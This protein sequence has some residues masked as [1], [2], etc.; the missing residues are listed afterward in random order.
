MKKVGDI[1]AAYL[2]RFQDNE[3]T[4][5]WFGVV[6]SWQDVVGPSLA[7]HTKVA[8]LDGDTLVI[9]AQHP[10]SAQLVMMKQTAILREVHRFYPQLVVARLRVRV[11]YS[12]DKPSSHLDH[13]ATDSS[14]DS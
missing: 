6:S 2:G 1:L 13:R 14:V 7:A 12:K 11:G 4:R 5:Q 8:D 9:E 10:A 3:D